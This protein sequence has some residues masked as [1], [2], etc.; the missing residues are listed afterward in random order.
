MAKW[1]RKSATTCK[2]QL[3][4]PA[5]HASSVPVAPRSAWNPWTMT[6]R[7]STLLASTAFSSLLVSLS[8][9]LHH[10]WRS[11]SCSLVLERRL[12]RRC[13]HRIPPCTYD[14]HDFSAL[15]CSFSFLP[16]IAVWPCLSKL[17]MACHTWPAVGS[18]ESPILRIITIGSQ[19]L[20]VICVSLHMYLPCLCM[21]RT[22]PFTVSISSFIYPDALQRGIHVYELINQLCKSWT[23]HESNTWWSLGKERQHQ[24]IQTMWV[25]DVRLTC[26]SQFF[27]MRPTKHFYSPKDISYCG[28]FVLSRSLYHV[29]IKCS[30]VTDQHASEKIRLCTFCLVCLVI[31]QFMLQDLQWGLLRHITCRSPSHIMKF[32]SGRVTA[33]GISNVLHML[34]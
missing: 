16:K 14:V 17:A 26:F 34:L 15:L 11:R 22:G 12:Q 25:T 7:S 2:A 13:Q 28:R 8:L 10:H 23:W 21:P 3:Q 24:V 18:S 30:N 1:S 33:I 4:A 32:M 27:R 6:A 29:F 31:L 9:V 19:R 5:L 20:K